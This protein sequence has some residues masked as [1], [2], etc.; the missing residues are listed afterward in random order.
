MPPSNFK[1]PPAARSPKYLS[2]V[3]DHACCFCQ[4]GGRSEAHHYGPRGMSQKTDDYRSVPACR[5]C[6]DMAQQ[7]KYEKL[8][9]ETRDALDAHVYKTQVNLL[10]EYFVLRRN[11]A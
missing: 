11:A 1:Q 2:F 9:F 6:H 7:Y 10:F 4:R 3:R 5:E 8:G